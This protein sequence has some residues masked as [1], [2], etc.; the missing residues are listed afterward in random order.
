M[1]ENRYIRSKGPQQ[2]RGK[3]HWQPDDIDIYN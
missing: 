2:A 3:L 1:V